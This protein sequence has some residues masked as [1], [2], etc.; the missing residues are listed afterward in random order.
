MR[1]LLNSINWGLAILNVFIVLGIC[2]CS[3]VGDVAGKSVSGIAVVF[4]GYDKIRNLTTWADAFAV[5]LTGNL[6]LALPLITSIASLPLICDELRTKNYYFHISRIGVKKYIH[7]KYLGCIIAGVGALFAGFVIFAIF[8][9]IS[10]PSQ[11]DFGNSLFV[12]TLVDDTWGMIFDMLK[13]MLYMLCWGTM[14]SI[15]SCGLVCLTQN[16]YIILCVP[17]LLNYIASRILLNT[18]ICLFLVCAAVFY[19]VGYSLWVRRYM[20]RI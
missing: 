4:E 20:L 6:Y 18:N 3:G 1:R 10:F 9:R 2:L 14:L 16:I 15:L 12:G 8:V 19:Y 13:V 11:Y 7:S 17:F 5:V